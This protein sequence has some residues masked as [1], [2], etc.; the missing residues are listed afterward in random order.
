MTM[1]ATSGMSSSSAKRAAS[2]HE[3]ALTAQ[4]M[5]SVE[6]GVIHGADNYTYRDRT[7]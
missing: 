1:A 5:F 7:C 2:R 6:P 4:A 3:K